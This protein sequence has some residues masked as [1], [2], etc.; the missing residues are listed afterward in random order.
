MAH[1]GQLK[2]IFKKW[3]SLFG[4]NV[5]YYVPSLFFRKIHQIP[6]EKNEFLKKI[7]ILYFYKSTQ[8]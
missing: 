8:T 7:F 1:F 4:W 2:N 6:I 3:F 5:P